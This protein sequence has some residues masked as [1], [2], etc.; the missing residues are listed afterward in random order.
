VPST[1]RIV[2]M[3]SISFW[4]LWRSMGFILEGSTTLTATSRFSFWT[5]KE[6]VRNYFND[7]SSKVK[8]I[9]IFMQLSRIKMNKNDR[10]IL[11]EKVLKICSLL[12]R[13]L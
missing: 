5:N 4:R 7:W 13:V 10:P 8:R 3:I 2:F 6:K 12:L 9:R 1:S 11:R